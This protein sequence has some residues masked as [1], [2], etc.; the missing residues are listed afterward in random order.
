MSYAQE[1]ISYIDSLCGITPDELQ[2]FFQGW[3]SP[4]SAETHLKLLEHSDEIVLAVDDETRNVAGFITSI[5]DG[6]L[7]AHITFLEV[8]PAYRRR[9]VGRELMRR[10]LAKLEGLYAV[11]LVCDA[12]MQPFYARFGMKR[13]VAMTLRDHAR[14]SG[15]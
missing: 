7:S 14:Q 2:G 1:T 11:D 10:M 8:L 15:A 12:E 9:G 3:P 4:P 13:S 5:S 6:V